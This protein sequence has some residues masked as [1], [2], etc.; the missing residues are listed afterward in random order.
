LSPTATLPS[1]FHTET[2]NGVELDPGTET[3]NERFEQLYVDLENA[4]LDS[5]ETYVEAYRDT[6]LDL[7]ALIAWREFIKPVRLEL[8]GCEP[9][10]SS[11]GGATSTPLLIGAL[12]NADISPNMSFTLT[13]R[14]ECEVSLRYATYQNGPGSGIWRVK[15]VRPFFYDE[16]I[17]QSLHQPDN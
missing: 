13:G 5:L 7:V 12:N 10:F 17:L 9:Y 15:A 16:F 1:Y 4:N 14:W 8:N 6:N 11:D 3:I 2:L